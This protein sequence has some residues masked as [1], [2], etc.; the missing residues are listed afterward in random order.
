MPR[1]GNIMKNL[2]RLILDAL[3][4][5]LIVLSCLALLVLLVAYVEYAR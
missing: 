3:I 4:P 1:G 2:P 5:Y